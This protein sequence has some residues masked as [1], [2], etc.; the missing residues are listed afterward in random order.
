[1]LSYNE[2]E[3]LRSSTQCSN[4]HVDIDGRLTEAGGGQHPRRHVRR[5]AVWEDGLQDVAGERERDDGQRG[6]VHDEDGAPQQQEPE[7]ERRRTQ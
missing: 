3:L 5:N 6:R 4:K 7:P 2:E 1:M